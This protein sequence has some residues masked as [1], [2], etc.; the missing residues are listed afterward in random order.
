MKATVDRNDLNRA[1]ALASSASSTRAATPVLTNVKIVASEGRIQLSGCDS[2]MWAEA[3]VAA[4]VETEGAVCVNQKL[5][6]DILGALGPGPMTLEMVDRHL[7][8]RHG[9][10]EWKMVSGTVAEFPP[11]PDVPE[12]SVLTLTYGRLMNAVD[13]VLYAC[14]DN[15]IKATLTG[16]LFTYDGEVLTLVA[17]DIHRMAIQKVP[18]PG[19]GNS[20][21]AV[22]PAKVLRAF[23]LL[24]VTEDQEI[25]IKFDDQ[26][27][28]LDVGHARIVA[29]LLSGK[30][31]NWE[32]VIPAEYTRSWMLD[33]EE[34][35]ANLRRTLIMARDGGNRIRFSGQGDKVILTASSPEKGDAKEEVGVVSRNGDLDIAF[36][37]K[38][39]L[40]AI[41]AMDSQGVVAELTDASRA[42]IIR[43]TEDGENHFCVIMPMS[44]N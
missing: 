24:G 41:Q 39:I 7:V 15:N 25:T 36:N 33:R 18:Q 10:S 2:E 37:G 17:T 31:P 27:L 20:L 22:V 44:I 40:E 9:M 13:R 19:I 16:V 1:L 5:L 42:A 38:F 23:K 35:Y 4:D 14:A 26:R 11:T 30:Y 43:P 6:A 29:Q 34:L 28:S 32:R 21:E 8:L 3:G 12:E